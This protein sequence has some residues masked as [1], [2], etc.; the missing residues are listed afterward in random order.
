MEDKNDDDVLEVIGIV[1]GI[2]VGLVLFLLFSPIFLLALII[3]GSSLTIKKTKWLTYT[4]VVCLIIFGVTVYFEGL[5]ELVQYLPIPISLIGMNGLI[6]PLQNYLNQGEPFQLSFA[7]YVLMISLSFVL[8]RFLISI[9]QFFKG[10]IVKPKEDFINDFRASKEYQKIFKNRFSLNHKYQQ[11]YREQKQQEIREK[12]F[13]DD[14]FLG[15]DEY[16]KLAHMSLGE[17]NQ[18]VLLQGTTGSGKTITTYSIIETTLMNNET[19]FFIDGKGDPKTINQLQSLCNYYGRNLHVFSETTKLKYNP[20]RNGNRTSVTDRIMATFD[21]SNEFYKNEAENQLQKVVHFLDDFDINRDI[22]NVTYYLSIPR[23][24]KVLSKDYELVEDVVYEKV[25][26]EKEVAA[27]EEGDD[28]LGM[29]DNKGNTDIEYE[30]VEK[31]VER[32][33]QTERAKKYMM[34]FFNKE[35]LSDEEEEAILN[36]EDETNKLFRGMQSQL[37]K[38]LYSELGHLLED[39]EDGIDLMVSVK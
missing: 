38:L 12:G 13:T 18:H 19:F 27:T 30:T 20:I 25:P 15:I 6:E 9:Y 29:E 36:G 10:K 2:L 8:S 28:P 35:D 26:V 4:S 24:Y 31:I 37:E 3:F 23:I 32:K 39:T 22:E 5:G 21:W 34:F 14:V 17:A 11:K 16:G 1:A 33:K 7:S